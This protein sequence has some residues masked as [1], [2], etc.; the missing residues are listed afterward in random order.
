[1]VAYAIP[2]HHNHEPSLL[3]VVVVTAIACACVAPLQEIPRYD[4]RLECFI[5]KLRFWKD[6][7]ELEKSL[8]VVRHATTEVLQSRKFRRIMEVCVS[9]AFVGRSSH[10]M[11][12]SL[13][14]DSSF[15]V[16]LLI[17]FPA[18]TCEGGASPRQ[19]SERR[20]CEGGGLYGFKLDALLKLATIK[21]QQPRPSPR[22]ETTR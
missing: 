2:L 9:A 17:L 20:H 12:H 10:S 3:S 11:A 22:F 4:A 13:L 7:E 8:D 21:V 18:R 5:F 1:M 6:S 14:S 15:C 19:L 16:L